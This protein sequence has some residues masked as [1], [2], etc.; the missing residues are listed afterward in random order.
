MKKYIIAF[1]ALLALSG[2]HAY[3]LTLN[4]LCTDNPS[5]LN[6]S[7]GNP[8]QADVAVTWQRNNPAVETGSITAVGN[9][10]TP[11]STTNGFGGS[12]GRPD[13]VTLTWT[14]PDGSQGISGSVGK[15]TPCPVLGGS[16]V[17]VAPVVQQVAPTPGEILATSTVAVVQGLQGQIDATTTDPTIIA[18]YQQIID[19]LVQII[20]IL[21]SR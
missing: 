2:G 18:L 16:P 6:W 7:V 5:T 8:D 3:A 14:L 4:A 9:A 19:L 10:T 11:F 12:G 21:G 17:P 1:T 13:S 20:A 15:V